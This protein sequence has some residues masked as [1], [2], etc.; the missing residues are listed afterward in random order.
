M[1]YQLILT[2]SSVIILLLKK[3][4]EVIFINKSKIVIKILQV[5][6]V[7]LTIISPMFLNL[8]GAYGMI[9]Q[10]NQNLALN[11][12]LMEYQKNL[13]STM[14]SY[15]CA[16]V[17]SSILMILSTILCLCKLDIIPMVT[18]STGFAI[19][20]FVMV[21]ISAIADKYGLTDS[22]LQPLSQKYFTR[23]FITIFP[24]LLLIAICLIRFFS[25]DK[26]SQRQQKRLNKIAKENAP[27]EK[28]I[29]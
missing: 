11:S 24:F 1:K 19:C 13:M 10:A 17:F 9:S 18:Q 29:D 5:L 12:D 8:L 14:N 26:R 6:L 15:G 2:L 28:I 16:M 3:C 27:C 7:I 4:L 23:H 25:Y 21:K 20:M 22:E